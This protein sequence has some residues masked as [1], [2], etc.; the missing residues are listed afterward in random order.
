MLHL[1]S[2]LV[3]IYT[4]ERLGEQKSQALFCVRNESSVVVNYRPHFE[5]KYLIKTNCNSCY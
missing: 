3:Y 5:E 2:E 4:G 1:N